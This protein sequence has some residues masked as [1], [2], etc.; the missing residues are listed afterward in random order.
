MA[1]K[2]LKGK[3]KAISSYKMRS[4]GGLPPPKD[5]LKKRKVALQSIAASEKAKINSIFI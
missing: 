5:A 3:A 4:K 1:P 2:E